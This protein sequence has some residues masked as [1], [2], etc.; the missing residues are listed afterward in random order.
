MK[1][2]TRLYVAA[3]AAV[4]VSLAAALLVL[5]PA[6]VFVARSLLSGE[7]AL[8]IALPKAAELLGATG[9]AAGYY[10]EVWAVVPEGVVEVYN[11]TVDPDSPIV[12]LTAKELKRVVGEW[13]GYYRRHGKHWRP[14]LLL[15]VSAYSPETDTSVLAFGA[16]VIY[17]PELF[18]SPLPRVEV[19]RVGADR[20]PVVRRTLNVSSLRVGRS[21]TATA[22][23][24]E[25][26]GL[27]GLAARPG[28]LALVAPSSYQTSGSGLPGPC[29]GSYSC[30]CCSYYFTRVRLVREIF[31]SGDPQL[32]EY[33]R[34][35]IPLI[36]MYMD[37]GAL[38]QGVRA[39]YDSG[40][41][42]RVKF[43]IGILN[44]ERIIIIGEPSGELSGHIRGEVWVDSRNAY[45][46]LTWRGR[47]KLY[48]AYGYRCCY[49]KLCD[50]SV[51]VTC[52]PDGW[53]SVVTIVTSVESPSLYPIFGVP[54]SE[55]V[56]IDVFRS[57]LEF[58]S[59]WVPAWG[60]LELGRDSLG[61]RI[62][63]LGLIVAVLCQYYGIPWY[64][65]YAI[66]AL[67][68]VAA[69]EIENV[70]ERLNVYNVGSYG[71]EIYISRI[72]AYYMSDQRPPWWFRP[73]F[74]DV[75]R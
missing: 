70:G 28:Y 13:L 12:R 14:A 74:I 2:P 45:S 65:C 4:V 60:V 47:F 10:V 9:R 5:E 16:S 42:T 49:A 25:A 61:F 11:A 20:F 48:D 1:R 19:H 41:Y 40:G 75:R 33:L 31:D 17:D 7:R 69:I 66:D 23:G 58:E 64:L 63:I 44:W 15:Q 53:S 46:F 72:A 36:I 39:Y 62:S 52:E 51:A 55:F 18:V 59:Y 30:D 24:R 37:P 29:S 56:D 50:G 57:K 71:A 21:A 27:C 54:A 6:Y 43:R 32:P 22:V 38:T 68:L 26:Q 3:S 73:P 34:N 67:G 8:V 35:V